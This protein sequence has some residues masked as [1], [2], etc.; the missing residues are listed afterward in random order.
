MNKQQQVVKWQR[1]VG[2][3]IFTIGSSRIG[4][5]FTISYPDPLGEGKLGKSCLMA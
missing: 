4:L 3:E 5:R 2:L 1:V